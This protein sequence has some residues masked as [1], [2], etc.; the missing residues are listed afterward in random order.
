MRYCA[1]HSNSLKVSPSDSDL[2]RF[3][4]LVTQMDLRS[5]Q[6]R[7]HKWKTELLTPI[8]ST[9][10]ARWITPATSFG[11]LWFPDPSQAATEWQGS[12]LIHRKRCDQ[13]NGSNWALPALEAQVFPADDNRL[14]VI[15]TYT[16]HLTSS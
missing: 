6:R 13:M 12:K 4:L 3:S 5:N 14:L 15:D 11:S 7:H 8:L 16:S 10:T 9:S 1:N 2:N